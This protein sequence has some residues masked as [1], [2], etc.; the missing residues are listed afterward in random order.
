MAKKKNKQSAPISSSP[1]KSPVNTPKQP[2]NRNT[3]PAAGENPG[4]LSKYSQL[5]I[6][7]GIALVTYVCYK[8]ILENQ[9]TNWDDLGYLI[10]DPLIKSTSSE[11]IK[12]MFGLTLSPLAAT[13]PVM[14]NY[15][16]L[17]ILIYAIEYSYVGLQPMLYHLDSLLLHILVTIAVYYFVKVLTGRTVAAA[18]VALLF[19]LHPMHV[20]SVAWAAGRK[21]VLYGLFYIMACTAYVFY[22]RTTGSKK[23]LWYIGVFVLYILSLLSKG[24]A[25]I[26]PITLLAIDFYEGR[27]LHNRTLIY[28]GGETIIPTYSKSRLNFWFLVDKITL[29]ALS[30]F[31]GKLASNTQDKIGAM[32]L[33]V[34]FNP[35][36]RFALGCYALCNYLWKAIVPTGLSNFYPY[37]LKV[38]D[39]LPSTYY[40]YPAII[41]A[42]AVAIVIFARKNKAILFG[43]GFFMINIVLLLQFI[44]VGGAIISDRYG[45]IP[46]LGLFFIAGWLVSQFFESKE[47]VQTGKIVLGIVVGYSLILGYMTNERSKDWYDA[48]TLW[49]DDIQ[50]HPEAPVGYFYLGQEYFTRYEKATTANEK[51]AY[52][53]SSLMM[54][55][56]SVERKPDYLSPII[57]I[58]ELQRNYGQIDAAKATYMKAMKIS[59]KDPSIY[60]GLGVIYSIKQQFD[61]ADYSFKKALSLKEYFPEAHSNY[62]NYLDIVGKLDSSLKEYGLAIQQNPDAYIPYMN[63]GRIYLRQNKIDEA[64]KDLNKAISLND[65]SGD[66]YYL[67]ARCYSIKGNKTQ[68]KQDADKAKSLGVKVDMNFLQLN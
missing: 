15:H 21:D 5:L 20:E 61:S 64:I 59:D 30:L 3:K 34:H 51:K 45:Y 68:A 13:N 1:A 26:L 31:F 33:D 17:T 38:N 63:R 42:L 44:P 9:L 28:D 40:V 35:F 32:T 57:C 62:A 49:K 39:A 6:V 46:Y 12:N 19:G 14:G 55:N 43:I 16:P 23:T 2:V 41:I 54:F 47:K 8:T 50:K 7:A 25:V 22:I 66:S 58:A 60:L 24:V 10:T 18:I 56:L 52:G 29:L 53:D 48:V 36:E 11:N 37:P 27:I 67:R 65:L 4:F